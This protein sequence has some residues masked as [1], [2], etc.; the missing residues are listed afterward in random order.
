MSKRTSRRS[1]PDPPSIPEPNRRSRS[2][3][4]EIKAESIEPEND[5]GPSKRARP[6]LR[7]RTK[8]ADE[9]FEDDEEKV[10][11]VRERKSVSYREVPVIED[12]EEVDDLSSAGEEKDGESHLTIFQTCGD[13][14]G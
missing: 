11:S 6:S 8:T 7:A 14:R 9:S 13:E 2:S 12:D 10:Y 5:P 3:R 1:A 4:N